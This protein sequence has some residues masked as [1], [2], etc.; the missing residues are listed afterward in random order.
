MKAE[1]EPQDVEEIASKVAEMLRP[2]L[3][4]KARGR[5]ED[6][7]FTV[8]ALAQYLGVSPSWVYKALSYRSIPHFKAGRHV[9]IDGKVLCGDNVH[10][11]DFV[12]FKGNVCLGNHVSV[13][14]GASISGSVVLD[15]TKIGTGAR[16]DSSLVGEKCVIEANAV[17]KPQT[18]L[19]NNTVIKK[20]SRV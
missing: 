19:G 13:G 1:L 12:Q 7:I 11:G 6:R 5:A 9:E 20:Y 10:I 17:L 2:L 16:V 14:K 18:A 8:E 3:A 4:P 15:G